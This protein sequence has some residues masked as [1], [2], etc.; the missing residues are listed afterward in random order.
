MKNVNIGNDIRVRNVMQRPQPQD[1]HSFSEQ[2]P[3]PN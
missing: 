3:N 1:Y 2:N